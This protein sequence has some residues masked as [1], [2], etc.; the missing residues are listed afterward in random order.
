MTFEILREN[1]AKA[2]LTCNKAISVKASLPILQNI[3]IEE[4]SKRIKL[5]ATDLDKSVMCFVGA[6]ITG[7]NTPVT[8]PAKV[9]ASFVAGLQDE[10]ITCE[11]KKEQ[12]EVVSKNAK[13]KFNGISHKEF[14]TLNYKIS[15]QALLINTDSLKRAI[16]ETYFSASLD[17]T[18]PIWTGILL[19]IVEGSMH[20]VA[21][22]G[23]RLSKKLVSLD[24][25]SKNKFEK[26]LQVVIPAKNLFE[27]IKLA[28]REDVIKID[29]QEDRSVVLFEFGD[30]LFVSKI[31]E[32]EYPNYEAV[33]PQNTTVAF[34]VLNE[35]L[36]RALKLASVFSSENNAV[37]L[38]V[39]PT[40]SII[41]LVSD[42]AELGNNEYVINITETSGDDLEIGFNAKNLL[43]YLNNVSSERINVK[44]S[45]QTSPAIFTPQGRSDYIH[46]TVPLQPYWES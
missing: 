4:D 25:L 13:A 29:I 36:L 24:E 12:L 30:T 44:L 28:S 21:L 10:T 19:K 11:I 3:L 22:D 34:S 1:F 32:G 2:L 41:K 27:V 37:R 46:V 42:S 15:D 6:K 9:L 33:I 31:I 17:D 20:V 16:D 8:I 23:F 45:G 39:K 40:E 43:D 26:D 5:T 35:D 7:E 18:K 14:P 38:M